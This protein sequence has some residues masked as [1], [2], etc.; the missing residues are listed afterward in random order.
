MTH[1]YTVTVFLR[2][3]AHWFAA[4]AWLLIL[5]TAYYAFAV[6]MVLGAWV[7]HN[8]LHQDVP[9]VTNRIYIA[10]GAPASGS[11]AVAATSA[12]V[13]SWCKDL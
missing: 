7:G 2:R 1:S 13:A 9:I 6:S 5:P 11:T 12:G 8:P 10:W 3:K 4:L